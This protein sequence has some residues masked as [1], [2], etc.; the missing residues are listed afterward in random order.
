[1]GIMRLKVTPEVHYV[2]LTLAWARLMSGFP[3]RKM[4]GFCVIE[5]HFD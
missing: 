1:M 2:I 3:Q 5:I 4:Q